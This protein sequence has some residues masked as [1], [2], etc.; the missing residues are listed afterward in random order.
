MKA[1]RMHKIIQMQQVTGE[2]KHQK[3]SLR[4]CITATFLILKIMINL[5]HKSLDYLRHI[6]IFDVILS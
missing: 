2:Q 1:T 4:E 3:L 6:I 5:T